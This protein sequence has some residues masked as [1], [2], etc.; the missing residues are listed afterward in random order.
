MMYHS[1]LRFQRGRGIGSIFS[2]LFR[3]LAPLA[4]MGLSAGKKFISS[5]IGK[6]L[7]DTAIDA[8]KQGLVNLT[9][10]ALSGENIIESGKRQLSDVKEKLASTLRGSGRKRRKRKVIGE[11]KDKKMKYNL[12]DD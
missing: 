1:G 12:L 11:I 8:G 4:K 6:K 9:A 5:G 7:A 3:G 10:D 2:S